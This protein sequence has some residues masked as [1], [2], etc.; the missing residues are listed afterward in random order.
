MF[1]FLDDTLKAIL[2]AA[3]VTGSVDLIYRAEKRI[4]TPE[5]GYSA[6]AEY[7]INFFLYEVIENR[8]L[9]QATPNRD[10]RNGQG[11]TS[12]AP[13][14]V[15]CAY[16]V[17]AWSNK[18]G[19]VGVRNS[20]NLL[21]Q[22]FNWLSQFPKIPER[23]L[24]IAGLTGQLF[25]PP[26]MVAQMDGAKSAGEFWS[27]LGIPP[28]PYFN[29]IVT[30]CMDLDQQIEDRLVTTVSTRYLQTGEPSSEEELLLIGGTVR[31]K[32]G[33]PV[34]DAW[35]RLEPLNPPQ[36]PEIKVTDQYGQFIFE[37]VILGSGFKLEAR[38]R[39][40]PEIPPRQFDA[41]PSASGEYDLQFP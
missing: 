9:R 30:I 13:L 5:K 27:A 37:K 22:A 10:L 41:V 23:Y 7:S 33:D 8:E 20:H 21:G 16:M 19:E 40:Y 25:E 17:T 26:T 34:P 1:H 15:D 14:R 2:A 35:V 11:S 18:G 38:A 32:A 31:N 12:R 6:N 29:L 3:P 28:R 39:G 36:V 4:E 24:T